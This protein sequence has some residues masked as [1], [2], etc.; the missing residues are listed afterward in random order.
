MTEVPGVNGD[1]WRGVIAAI[2]LM[3]IV[4]ACIALWVALT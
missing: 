4:Y 2:I 3:L 1:F